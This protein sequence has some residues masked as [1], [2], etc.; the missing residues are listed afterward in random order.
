MS[1]H[2]IITYSL[3]GVPV[4]DYKAERFAKNLLEMNLETSTENVVLAARVLIKEGVL[5]HK[6]IL[7]VYKDESGKEVSSQYA[8][9][10]GR[11]E[12]WPKGF[13]DTNENFLCR[14]LKP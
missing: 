6:D 7:F 1:K 10:D 8:D 2:K 13:C 12:N 14:I 3:E 4:S 5:S 9:K 11:L